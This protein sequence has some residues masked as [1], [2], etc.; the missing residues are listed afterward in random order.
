MD[1]ERNKPYSH[2]DRPKAEELELR[3]A[4]A[5]AESLTEVHDRLKGS[6]F[7]TEKKLLKEK[8]IFE[9]DEHFHAYIRGDFRA[10]W[11]HL[12]KSHALA[13]DQPFLHTLVHM[14]MLCLALRQRDCSQMIDQAWHLI[15]G[16]LFLKRLRNRTNKICRIRLSKPQSKL[17]QQKCNS[18]CLCQ[19]LWF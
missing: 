16:S 11:I 8:V 1:E 13:E 15:S 18:D 9:W 12:E 6:A 3:L 14:K 7:V 4:E 19:E 10:A 2:F 5:N 17:F